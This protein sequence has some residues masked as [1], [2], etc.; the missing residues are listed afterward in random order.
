[1]NK[2]AKSGQL[3]VVEFLLSGRNDREISA[4]GD[5]GEERT[6]LGWAASRGYKA[7]VEALLDYSADINLCGTDGCTP[8]LLASKANHE[9]V[10][11]VLLQEPAREDSQ[12][13]P[14][15]VDI[16]APDPSDRYTPLH[17]AASTGN[18]RLMKLLLSQT[19]KAETSSESLDT[20]LLADINARTNFL[21]TPL[22]LA[23]SNKDTVSNHEAAEMLLNFGAEVDIKD[24]EGQTALHKATLGGDLESVRLLI[25]KGANPNVTDGEGRRPVYEAITRRNI[26]LIRELYERQ[27]LQ[28][29]LWED[30]EMAIGNCTLDLSAMNVVIFL[31]QRALEMKKAVNDDGRTFLHVAAEL[32]PPELIEKLINLKLDVNSLDHESRTPLYTAASCGDRSIVVQEL[33]NFGA[34]TNKADISGNSPLYITTEQRDLDTCNVL[35]NAKASVDLRGPRGETALYRASY[36]G[37]TEIVETLLNHGANPNLCAISSWSPL[38]AAYDN[39]AI[40][41]LLVEKGADINYQKSDLWGPMHMSAFRG[42]EEVVQVLLDKGAEPNNTDSEGFTP[43]HFAILHGK[44]SVL[45]I[46]AKHTGTIDIDFEKKTPGR[47]SPIQLAAENSS[48][49]LKILLKKGLDPKTKTEDGRSCI[50]LAVAA[51]NHRSLEI[52]L[53]KSWANPNAQTS[54]DAV[55][56]RDL[57]E[58]I[59]AYWVAVEKAGINPEC[60]RVLVN[61]EPTLV[62]QVSQEGLNGLEVYLRGHRPSYEKA[63][64]LTVFLDFGHNP[65][66]R[67]DQDRKSPFEL[68]VISK[69]HADASFVSRCLK[70]LPGD[71]HSLDLGFEELRIVTEFDD[72]SNW[73]VLEPLR[74]GIHDQTDK[75]GWSIDHF[76]YQ[77][78]PRVEFSSWRDVAVSKKTKTAT[79]LIR[80]TLWKAK[81]E[82]LESRLQILENG[83]EATFGSEFGQIPIY[84]SFLCFHLLIP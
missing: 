67:H 64:T 33:I 65:F 21:E 51:A 70:E 11:E 75:D 73:T 15:Q 12:D 77:S 10:V 39:P 38:H 71:I 46:M 82:E 31:V 48:A 52:L 69:C 62:N 81:D 49:C 5:K 27:Y 26:P 9:S 29:N 74:E 4:N 72:K 63:S 2:A 56:K 53:T 36:S 80:P 7:V 14:Q 34:D 59:A 47:L 37:Y 61:K 60:L 17:Y 50:D 83:L 78:N 18:L 76:L 35:L 22:H 8:L 43:L 24:I 58:L 45:E 32:G 84:S 41:K 16:N 3:I 79:S 28:E 30:V 19:A 40:T 20:P 23:V 55:F 57:Q 68:G 42:F 13:E 54:E 44:A 66:R 1:M 25:S 6:P